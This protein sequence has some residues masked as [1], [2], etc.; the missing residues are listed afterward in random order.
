MLVS[1]APP[2]SWRFIC[3]DI[4]ENTENRVAF[5]SVMLAHQVQL[6]V[7]FETIG[8]LGPRHHCRNSLSINADSTVSSSG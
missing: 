2:H 7:C 4:R 8:L 5:E 1:A 6:E 3:A